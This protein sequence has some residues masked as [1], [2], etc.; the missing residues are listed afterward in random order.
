MKRTILYCI[1]SSIIL[2]IASFYLNDRIFDFFLS[3]FK[4]GRLQF[5]VNEVNSPFLAT[6]KLGLSIGIIPLLLLI[7]WLAGKITSFRRRLFSVLIMIVCIVLAIMVNV[8]RISSHEI[9]MTNLPAVISFPVEELFFE[10]AIGIGSIVG[11]AISYFIF[12]ERR[13]R[14]MN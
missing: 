14:F 2:L 11:A 10:Y 3:F 12:R 6:L 13:N 1:I 7:V 5:V 9:V 4:S 8:F